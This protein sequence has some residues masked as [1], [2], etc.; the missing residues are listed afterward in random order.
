MW[1]HVV[2]VRTDVSEKHIASII[3]VE[4]ISD[5]GTA[6]AVTSNW[7]KLWRNTNVK[8]CP[9]KRRFLQEPH[10][11]ISQKTAFFIVT[12]LTISNLR[13]KSIL[14][15][16]W[17]ILN[18]KWYIINFLMLYVI[19]LC[20]CLNPFNNFYYQVQLSKNIVSWICLFKMFA[21]YQN[22]LNWWIIYCNTW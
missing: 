3:R 4:R 13:T 21:L 6:L 2:L 15:E 19:L 7:C 8:L 11:I 18:Y 5:L 10:S 20:D 1:C 17:Y 14:L 22:A 9:P 12:T 16:K